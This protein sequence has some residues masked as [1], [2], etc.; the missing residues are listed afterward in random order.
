M[1][2]WCKVCTGLEHLRAC[3]LFTTMP[4]GMMADNRSHTMN[5][6]IKMR[7]YLDLV[8]GQLPSAAIV[9]SA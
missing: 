9:T 3:A 5:A 2:M 4:Y 1:E 6:N 8:G 7:F